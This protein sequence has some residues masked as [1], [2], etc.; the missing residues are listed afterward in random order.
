M[1]SKVAHGTERVNRIK[2]FKV[3]LA[4]K[5][6]IKGMNQDYTI[7]YMHT[8][9]FLTNIGCCWLL[10]YDYFDIYTNYG[11]LSK[12]KYTTYYLHTIHNYMCTHLGIYFH[13][14]FKEMY[15]IWVRFYLENK[16]LKQY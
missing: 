2:D 11:G 7:Q 8:H 1:V 15:N 5:G 13:T 14:I 3:L 16:M 4:S 12:Y 10:V 6:L 9:N